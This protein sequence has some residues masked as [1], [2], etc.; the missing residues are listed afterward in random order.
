MLLCMDS[1]ELAADVE[2]FLA[3]GGKINKM[4]DC[5]PKE[6]RFRSFKIYKDQNN[7]KKIL[8]RPPPRGQA[9]PVV[10]SGYNSSKG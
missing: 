8:R 7:P 10:F 6:A 9:G 4:R 2:A 5:T 1:E 3:K